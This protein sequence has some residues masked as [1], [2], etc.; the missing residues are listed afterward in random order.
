MAAPARHRVR[1]RDRIS[2]HTVFFPLAAVHAALSVPLWLASWLGWLPALPPA[3]H[4][5][6][7][8]AGF[9]LAVV[10]GFL[11]TRPGRHDLFLA[12]SAWLA[13]RVGVWLP[14]PEPWASLCALAYP[15]ALFVM[16]GLPFLRASKSAHNAIFGPLIGAFIPVTL[17]YRLSADPGAVAQFGLYLVALLLFTMGGRIIP[18][19]AAGALRR[20]GGLLVERVQRPLEWTGIAAIA[21]AGLLTQFDSLGRFAAA[22][23]ILGGVIALW[24]LLRWRPLDTLDQPDLWSLNLGYAW[25]GIGLLLAG[26]QRIT[27]LP[28][29]TGWH[30]L[31][32]G[33]LGTLAASMM[34]RASLQRGGLP[35][36]FPPAATVMVVLIGLATLLRLAVA[37]GGGSAFLMGSAVLWVAA[38]LLLLEILRRILRR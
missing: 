24:R 27:P 14:L 21:T 16:A 32:V 19:A 6:E 13:G 36:A 33:A 17:L 5:Q 37:L 38:Y 12:V 31:S 9:A 29:A 3:A 25:L 20:K 2:G 28:E 8:L 11:L 22:A 15:V 34:V 23:S 7:M 35:I 18:A 4:A 10:G 26:V 30:A 1:P